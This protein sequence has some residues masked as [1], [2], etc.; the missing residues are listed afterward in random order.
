MELKD[1]LHVI[2]VRKW[3]II[4][5]VLV[6]TSTAVGVS[7]LMPNV[8]EGEAKVL[9]TAQDAG[10]T[11]LGASLSDLTNNPDRGL[12][13]QVQMMQLRPL[14]ERVI[15]ELGL[16]EAPDKL[17]ARVTVSGVGQT[18]IVTI[19]ASDGSPHRA[20]K[21]AQAMAVAYVDRSRELKRAS[22]TTAADQVQA[23][24]DEAKQE[25]LDLGSR[26]K[27]SSDSTN[28]HALQ[29]ELTIATN[30][31]ATLAE[32][33]ETLKI[34]EQLEV[35]SGGVVEPATV[36]DEPV[37]PKPLRNGALGLAVGLVFGLGMAF[38]AEYMDNTIKSTDEVEALY[39]APVLGNVPTEQ[40]DK[41]EK[42]RLTIVEKPGSRAAE[43]YR[44][45]RNGIDY[46]NFEHDI[47]TLLVTSAA[48]AEGK[49]T[50]SANLAA[51]LA[52]AGSKVVLL[53]CDFRRPTTDQFFH[54]DNQVGL[55]DVLAGRVTLAGALQDSG[56]KNLAVLAPGKMPPNPS[57]LLGSRT[58]TDLI[59][60]LKEAHDWVIVDS[61]PLLAVADAAATARWADGV[62]VVTR[63]GVS[64]HQAADHA[65][66]VLEKVGAR[67][68]GIVVWGLGDAQGSS[69]S[70]GN[71]YYGGY[72]ASYADVGSCGS[73]DSGARNT[74]GVRSARHRRRS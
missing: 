22:I 45:L 4:T 57:E 67:V 20:A 18:N 24:L 35:G 59:A 48:P 71:Y 56:D 23:R 32:K 30:L 62:L 49:S 19:K 47:K 6:V 13:T 16:T 26:F 46:V 29:A 34:N 42:R 2:R 27:G 50:V 65:H 63:A 74:L 37:S 68:V 53:N 51:A 28:S 21:I 33:Y 73:A 9:I 7:M 39:G 31:Y 69:S 52:M 36:N 40:L 66:D 1:Y 25:I 55:S 10:S 44:G 11:L 70:Y 43:A 72:Y 64:T 60:E 12:Q 5:A 3:I 17:L 8:Y 41:D 15:R 58:M 14:A 61:P 54:V 38:L